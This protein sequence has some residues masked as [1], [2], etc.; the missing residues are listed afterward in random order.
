MTMFSDAK[1]TNEKQWHFIPNVI[2]SRVGGALYKAGISRDVVHCMNVPPEKKAEQDKARKKYQA[3]GFT[4]RRYSMMSAV[5]TDVDSDWLFEKAC[6]M[7][8]D[9]ERETA[10][11]VSVNRDVEMMEMLLEQE[12]SDWKLKD[13][14][15]KAVRGHK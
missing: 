8:R 15:P 5:I 2:R 9:L 7:L 12:V 14:S 10:Q 4:D 11:R 3:A 6:K 13:G 1:R